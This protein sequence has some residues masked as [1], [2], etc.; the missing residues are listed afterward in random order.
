MTYPNTLQEIEGGPPLLADFPQF[1]EP[2]QADRRFLAPPVVEDP[3]GRL[4][5]RAWR[6]WYNARGIVETQNRLEE[7]ATAVITV[8]PWGL[9][10][11]HG[12]ETPQ[13]AGCAFQCTPE[14]NQVAIQHM[15]QVLS[16][17]LARLRPHVAV[18]A[19]AMPG[20]ED[21]IR[22]LIYASILTRPE[23]LDV[24]EG[25]RQLA[26]VLRAWR[27]RGE[28]LTATVRLDPARPASSY[29]D[30]TPSTDAGDKYN[31]P[32]Y[33]DLPM[34]V[35]V[36]LER[37]ST[38]LV[39]YDGEGYEKVR[40]FLQSRGIRHVLLT[41]YNLDMCVIS[42]TCGYLN[43]RQ[44]FNAFVVGDATLATFPGSVTPRFTTQAALCSAALTQLLTQVGWVEMQS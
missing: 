39:F 7:R 9:D 18:V 13:P 40:D 22:K 32:G 29:M 38:D 16:P 2:L 6:W 28:P 27:F 10:D 25:E 15:R 19:S 30:Q 41:G 24:A 14:K 3:G 20:V 31:G 8:H 5:V 23:E 17:F 37:E 43:L 1:V 36:G 12:L 11:G 35:S 34:P 4:L 44:D 42:T 26:A 21:P 33:W